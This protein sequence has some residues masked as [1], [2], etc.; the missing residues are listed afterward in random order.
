MSVTSLEERWLRRHPGRRILIGSL[1]LGA[2]GTAPLLLYVLFGPKNG[3]PIG[4]GL[5][6]VVAIPVCVVGAGVGLIKMIVE[7][8]TRHD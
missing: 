7:H 3:N 4:L 6:A 1:V 5:L 8:F 2:V